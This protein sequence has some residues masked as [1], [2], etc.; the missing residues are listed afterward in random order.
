MCVQVHIPASE[1]DNLPDVSI[2]DVT[3]TQ[4]TSYL[5][6]ESLGKTLSEQLEEQVEQR[7]QLETLLKTMEQVSMYK[8]SYIL[9]AKELQVKNDRIEE[10]GRT[11]AELE[12]KLLQ[13]R[14]VR[15]EC[16]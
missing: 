3:P 12:S 9:I 6:I 7:K 16:Y 2:S 1:A 5:E 10:L 14:A 4:L 8:N 15:K 11:V 13:P